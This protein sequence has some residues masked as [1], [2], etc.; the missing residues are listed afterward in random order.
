MSPLEAVVTIISHM[1]CPSPK[2]RFFG[3]RAAPSHPIFPRYANR[4]S[5]AQ[6][7]Y[8]MASNYLL[9]HGSSAVATAK[10]PESAGTTLAPTPFATPE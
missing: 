2:C 7:G 8:R 10:E 3:F 6:P 1:A 4:M 9:P 5:S